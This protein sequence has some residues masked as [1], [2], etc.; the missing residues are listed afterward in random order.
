MVGIR[1]L[2]SMF[3]SRCPSGTTFTTVLERTMSGGVGDQ[4]REQIDDDPRHGSTDRELILYGT[5]AIEFPA[6][7]TRHRASG[8]SFSVCDGYRSDASSPRAPRPV[9]HR[10]SIPES[11]SVR[12]RSNDVEWC[13]TK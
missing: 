3:V 13:A 8:T 12:A 7:R 6:L 9:W 11:R 1:A 5:R 2:H 10:A 4:D